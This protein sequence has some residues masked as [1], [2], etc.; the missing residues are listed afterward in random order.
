M[1]KI[2]CRLL[3]NL[4]LAS[5]LLLFPII[6]NV[7]AQSDIIGASY[8]SGSLGY[9]AT[10]GTGTLIRIGY[11]GAERSIAAGYTGL[12]K[13]GTC[14]SSY[15]VYDLKGVLA[16]VQFPD[17]IWN[18]FSA[19]FKGD[20]LF[21][22]NVPADQ[23]ITWLDMP[24]GIRSWN[25]A[26]S[27]FFKLQADISYRVDDAF[28]FIGGFCWESL[29]TTFGDPNPTYPFT[30][31]K[32]ESGL[33]LGVYQPFV[34]VGLNQRVGPSVLDVRMVG[35]PA[36]IATLE[37]FNTCNNHVSPLRMLGAR[38]SEVVIFS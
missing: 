35:F 10:A 24:T 9:E 33:G 1:M 25:W 14:V 23:E 37:H 7:W 19:R 17:L 30:I 2:F 3:C 31:S 27:N 18:N 38:T 21:S 36:M 11:M 29:S 22:I 15:F 4:L 8:T 26:K 28:N 12:V 6:S 20:Y 16:S 34:G 32:M 5:M 13:P